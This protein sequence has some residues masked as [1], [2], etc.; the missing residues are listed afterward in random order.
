MVRTM[1]EVIE[2]KARTRMSATDSIASW[3]N[4]HA[5]FLQTRFFGGKD[6]KTPFKR[7][8]HKEYT[9][10]LL[11]EETKRSRS[12]SRFIPGIWLG[13]ATESDEH[14]VGIVQGVYTARSVRAKN[15]QEIWNS[16]LIKSVKGTPWAPRGEDS[17]AEVRMPEERHGP[18]IG[19]NTNTRILRDFWDEIGKTAGCAA[20]ASPGGKKHSVACLNRQEEWKT[21]GHPTTRTRDT[22]YGRRNAAGHPGTRAQFLSSHTNDRSR[23]QY[24][25][26][27]G[28]RHQTLRNSKLPTTNLR[29]QESGHTR[30]TNSIE[31]K[32]FLCS[33]KGRERRMQISNT[34]KRTSCGE[35]E[36]AA[37][38][39]R[40]KSDQPEEATVQEQ[41]VDDI[42]MD[43]GPR[44]AGV[45]KMRMD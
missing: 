34:W 13:R 27:G 35:W 29:I 23:R 41:R 31:L 17:Q 10:Q 24:R 21:R 15:D 25:E 14:I 36:Q 6:G 37:L 4:R 2:D 26:T 20:C 38:Q 16:G 40:G 32:T 18:M 7:R 3:M 11:P 33:R 19:W 43:Q 5:A 44:D 12:D 9:N 42:V 45:T 39:T 8:H 1:K 28:E 30:E 22:L